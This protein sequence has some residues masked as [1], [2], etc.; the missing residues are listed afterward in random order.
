M[1]QLN[2]MHKSALF[3]ALWYY[4]HWIYYIFY[5]PTLVCRY[6]NIFHY[7]YTIDIEDQPQTKMMRVIILIL[8]PWNIIASFKSCLRIAALLAKTFSLQQ[9]QNKQNK[10]AKTKNYNNA[11]NKQ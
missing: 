5:I 8:V 9:N 10:Q 2:V 3:H 4:K 7:Q 1:S 11:C 6:W